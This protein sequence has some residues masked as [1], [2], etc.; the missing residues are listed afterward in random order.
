VADLLAA[1]IMQRGWCDELDALVPIPMSLLR[2]C[3]RPCDHAAVLAA[4]LAR[5]LKLPLL[6]ALRRVRHTPSLVGIA[7]RA[8]R[9]ANVKG[10]FGPRRWSRR[11]VSRKCICI[12]DNLL[13]TG[14][15]I[16]EASKVLRRAGAR[17]IYAAVIARTVLAGD[18]QAPAAPGWA[19]PPPGDAA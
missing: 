6:R 10:A 13:A 16:H 17:R 5:R 2:R 4:A 3:Q 18:T 19:E 11:V 12:V 1:A 7:S 14:A 15:T 8:Q 9:F